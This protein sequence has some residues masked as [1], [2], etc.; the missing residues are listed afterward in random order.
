MKLFEKLIQ[1]FG[2]VWFFLLNRH[3]YKKLEF[4]AIIFK[5][6]IIVGREYITLC[7]S[8]I[9][10]Q[11]SS[12][13]A[14]RIDGNDPELIMNEGC[15]LGYNNHIAAVRRVVLGKNV[16]T[17][18]NVYISD[19]LHGY[20]NVEI[21][22][23]HQPVTY[24]ADVS[25]GDGSWIGENACILGATIGTNCVIGANSVVTGDIP[26]YSVAVG[27]PARVIKR[28]NINSKAWERTA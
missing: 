3:R 16:Q 17:A 23:M 2:M 10:R 14:I 28:Y 4:K 18:N 6:L 25:I 8:V 27:A 5:P 20:E 22:V 19:N 13:Y 9:V 12:L 7:R 21:P 26:D 1:F 11:N 15:S 24:K